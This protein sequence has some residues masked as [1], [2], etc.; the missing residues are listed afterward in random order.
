MAKNKFDLDFAQFLDYARIIDE[1]LGVKELQAAAAEAL[2]KSAMRANSNISVAMKKS[3]YAFDK[4][5][6]TISKTGRRNQPATGK[7]KASLAKVA[8]KEVEVNGTTITAYAGVNLEE[9]PEVVMLATGTPH[10]TAD[11]DLNNAI[12]C[13]GK[14]KREVAQIQQQVFFQKVQ[15]AAKAG[16][17][18]GD[19]LGE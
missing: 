18:L 13:K 1:R 19:M 14:Y 15:A 10:I 8:R 2:E 3:R 6:Q 12:K 16:E 7:A 9:A 4:G 11:R 17:T 5:E